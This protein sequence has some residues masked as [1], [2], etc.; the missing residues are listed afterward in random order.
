[1][2]VPLLSATHQITSHSLSTSTSAY[3]ATGLVL[4]FAS[5]HLVVAITTC[6]LPFAVLLC[7]I[8]YLKSNASC[9]FLQATFS[10]RTALLAFGAAVPGIPF[11]SSVATRWTADTRLPRW[12]CCPFRTRQ[13]TCRVIMYVQT[14][15]HGLEEMRVTCCST[16]LLLP[17]TSLTPVQEWWLLC[18]HYPPISMSSQRFVKCF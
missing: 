15:K 3:L 14:H 1:M 17:A 13:P 4:M 6:L 8:A 5:Y 9:Y 16:S 10:A 11:A 12:R 18:P 2:L 7:C